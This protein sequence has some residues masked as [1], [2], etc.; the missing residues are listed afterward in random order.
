MAREGTCHTSGHTGKYQGGSGDGW[1][2]AGGGGGNVGKSF[3]VV[4]LGRNG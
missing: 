1:Q 2:G 3:I 4:S